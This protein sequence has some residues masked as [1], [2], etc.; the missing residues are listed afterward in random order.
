MLIYQRVIM[1]IIIKL[2]FTKTAL[3]ESISKK[4]DIEPA[5]NIMF[6]RCAKREHGDKDCNGEFTSATS[7]FFLRLWHNHDIFMGHLWRIMLGYWPAILNYCQI[8][9]F[10]EM[11]RPGSCQLLVIFHGEK[12]W[13]RL[14]WSLQM[15]KRCCPSLGCPKPFLCAF[16]DSAFM[17]L[18]G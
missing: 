15:V 14:W 5:A 4:F 11:G 16:F 9:G 18:T 8:L 12:S 6:L 10:S 1:I 13:F 17:E 7:V 2:R 3:Q